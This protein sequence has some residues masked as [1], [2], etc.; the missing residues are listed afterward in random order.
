[1]TIKGLGPVKMPSWAVSGPQAVGCRPL[2]ERERE[3]ERE[4]DFFIYQVT[5][6]AK[7]KTD[8]LQNHT[9]VVRKKHHIFPNFSSVSSRD[10]DSSYVQ[11]SGISS[12]L[13]TRYNVRTLILTLFY[14]YV[15]QQDKRALQQLQ[16]NSCYCHSQKSSHGSNHRWAQV[17]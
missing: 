3:R 5:R 13:N 2:R 8:T 6:K 4:R 7:K 12:L 15:W 9:L 11:K 14:Q 10:T 1:M 16:K 17:R